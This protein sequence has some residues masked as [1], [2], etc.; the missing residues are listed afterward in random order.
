MALGKGNAL[1]ANQ[2]LRSFVDFDTTNKQ[3]TFKPNETGKPLAHKFDLDAHPNRHPNRIP[4]DSTEATGDGER[5]KLGDLVHVDLEDP[6]E[7]FVTSIIQRKNTG[8]IF[9]TGTLKDESVQ[10]WPSTIVR[11]GPLFDGPKGSEKW[12]KW[13]WEKYYNDLDKK[14]KLPLDPYKG[15]QFDWYVENGMMTEQEVRELKDEMKKDKTL[16]DHFVT[17]QKGTIRTWRVGDKVKNGGYVINFMR[18]LKKPFGMMVDYGEPVRGGSIADTL[19][20]MWQHIPPLNLSRAQG[21]S[22]VWKVGSHAQFGHGKD[23]LLWEVK[24]FVVGDKKNLHAVLGRADQL[25]LVPVSEL[26]EHRLE[27]SLKTFKENQSG[28]PLAH[29]FEVIEPPHEPLVTHDIHY[30][31]NHPQKPPPAVT[32]DHELS[33]PPEKQKNH[34]Q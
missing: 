6:V 9:V 29:K 19:E 15:F 28:K 34:R 27:H 17:P 16:L 8:K 24:Y 5:I 7:A 20:N 1:Q 21:R 26:H 10:S 11:F 3:K 33:C 13:Q 25:K 23:A 4:L 18:S 12:D 30:S 22:Q 2:N 32:P 14:K 31:E